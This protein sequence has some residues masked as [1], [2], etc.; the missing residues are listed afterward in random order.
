M[1]NNNSLA[2]QFYPFPG[3]PD[4]MYAY[5]KPDTGIVYHLSSADKIV[6]NYYAA[7]NCGSLDCALGDVNSYPLFNQLPT[8]TIIVCRMDTNILNA[9]P[10][11]TYEWSTGATTPEINVSDT[12]VYSVLKHHGDDNCPDDLKK[13][14]IRRYPGYLKPMDLGQDT[15]IC[16]GQQIV[17][18]GQGPST[19]WST[20][21]TGSNITIREPGTYWAV[22]QDT[23]S[24]DIVADT[25]LLAKDTCL[26]QYCTFN[27]PNAFSPNGDGLNDVLAPVYRGQLDKYSFNIFNRLGQRV[28]SSSK[29]EEGWDGRIN[30]QTADIGVYFYNC[31]FYCP[32]RGYIQLKG[33]IS[34][35]R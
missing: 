22:L 32:L 11:T 24:L 7:A 18:Q 23:C 25:M 15:T 9:G 19:A 12:G 30:G 4:Y 6:A 14:V 20:G 34:L 31:L 29:P 27:V 5:I 8:D 1:L 26:W 10:G 3:N 33:D 35:I 28:F 13:F 2:S 17:L 21:E 16:I